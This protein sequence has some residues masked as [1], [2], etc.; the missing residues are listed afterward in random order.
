MTRADRLLHVWATTL[1]FVA[2]VAAALAQARQDAPPSTFRTGTTLVEVAAVVVDSHGAPI[3]DLTEHDFSVLEDGQPRPLVSF[4]RSEH[5]PADIPPAAVMSG[6]PSALV[7]TNVDTADVPVFVLLLDDLNISPYRTH[8]AIRGALGLLAAV[9][10][11]AL[12][13]IVTSSGVGSATLN[14]AHPDPSHEAQ[15]RAFRGQM[16]VQ[17]SAGDKL[18]FVTTRSSTVGAPCGVGSANRSSSTCVDPARATR[19]LRVLESVARSLT[20]AGSR[21]KVLF[22]VTEDMGVTPLNF[23]EGQ[24][25]QREALHAVLAADVAVYPVHPDE[26][27]F[28]PERDPGGTLMVGNT[29]T[30]ATSIEMTADDYAAVTLDQMARESGGR[31]IVDINNHERVLADVVRQNSISYLLAYES[32]SGTQAGRRRIDV[33]VARSGARVYA[34]RGY[35]VSAPKIQPEAGA[36]GPGHTLSELLSSVVPQGDLELRVAAVPMLTRAKQGRA[37]ITVAVDR[38]SADGQPVM[39]GML[40]VNAEGD[41][42]NRQVLRMNAPPES[43]PWEVT[44]DL[45]LGKG[46]HQL[47]IA[48]VTADE[49]HQGLVALPVVMPKEPKALWM[50][51]PMLL[52]AVK[53]TSGPELRPTTARD[54]PVGT[55][56]AV[57]AQVAGRDLRSSIRQGHLRLVDAS[58]A[59]RAEAETRLENTP[60]GNSGMLSGVVS[61][62]R[63]PPGNYIALLEVVGTK[64]NERIAQTLTIRL[65]PAAPALASLNRTLVRVAFGRLSS[66]SGTETLVLREHEEWELF[67]RRLSGSTQLP[68]IDFARFTLVAVVMD[69]VDDGET[70]PVIDGVERTAGATIVTWRS[71]PRSSPGRPDERQRD[72]PFEV[73]AIPRTTERLEFRRRQ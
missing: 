55:P 37:V 23:S 28:A 2:A 54:L 45:Q 64:K 57:S 68:D 17:G 44:M 10:A 5:R 35:I 1:L 15:V 25:A 33:R 20:R 61:T 41:I 72:R 13:G 36:T 29:T 19:R 11:S 73:A 27:P 67:W 71:N 4:K 65:A 42:A 14:F 59:T 58:G 12:V 47:R 56:I 18:N 6:V 9:P 48:G 21:R 24:R 22:W 69:P 39:L 16:L 30:G 51:T 53:S 63:L 26:L 62:E 38:N 46:E 40:T 3:R 31:W 8:R 66:G 49:K 7:T 60:E 70:T 52:A 32:T 50:G 34:R 43:G